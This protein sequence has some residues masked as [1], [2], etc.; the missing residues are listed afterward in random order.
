MEKHEDATSIL[1]MLDLDNIEKTISQSYYDTGPEKPPK[2]DA[3]KA[4]IVKRL[5]QIPRDQE[6]YRR[7]WNDENLRE[8]CD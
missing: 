8:I 1:S 4:L 7:L 3:F 5:R 6:L 2:I